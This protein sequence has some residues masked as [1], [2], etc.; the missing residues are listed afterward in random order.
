MFSV[1]GVGSL[2]FGCLRDQAENLRRI[3]LLSEYSHNS[4]PTGV[5]FVTKGLV[6]TVL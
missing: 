4:V 6:Y 1:G 2:G 5:G 3:T